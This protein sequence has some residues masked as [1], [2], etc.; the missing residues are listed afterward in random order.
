MRL[1]VV[2]PKEG[3]TGAP[4]NGH[5]CRLVDEATGEL[6]ERVCRVTLDV[7]ADS[8]AKTTVEFI[9]LPVEYRDE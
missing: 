3:A 6:V 9:A 8:V 4:V 7:V 1:K 5:G 2:L